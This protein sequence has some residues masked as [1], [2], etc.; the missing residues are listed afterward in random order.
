MKAIQLILRLFRGVC[1]VMVSLAVVL[2]C[3]VIRTVS[4]LCFSLVLLCVYVTKG[5]NHVRSNNYINVDSS[6]SDA[7]DS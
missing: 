1:V 7:G 2:V 5:K 6:Y 3:L 4:V